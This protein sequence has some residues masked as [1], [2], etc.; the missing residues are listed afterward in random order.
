MTLSK[1]LI[2]LLT[3]LLLVVFIGT[4]FISVKNSRSYIEVQLAS[5]A[6]DAATSLG[7]AVTHH[8]KEGDQAMVTSMTN[9][10]FDRGFYRLIRVESADG[11]VLVERQNQVDFEGIPEWF[12]RMI[13]LQVP[14]GSS[15]LMSGWKQMGHV[16]VTSNPGYAY[17]QLWDNV[18]DTLIWFVLSALIVGGIGISLLRLIVSPLRAMEIQAIAISNQEF[19]AIDTL[20]RTR[21][22][23]GI[24]KAMN[25]MSHKVA[26]VFGELHEL[27]NS[28]CKSSLLDPITELANRTY[29]INTLTERVHSSEEF[30]NGVL[31]LVQVNNLRE[32][33]ELAGREFGDRLLKKVADTLREFEVRYPESIA[34]HISGADFALLVGDISVDDA[35][36]LAAELS[37]KL[38]LIYGD[39]VLNTPDFCHIGMA[40]Y[41]GSQSWSELM[42]AA[43]MALRMAIGS[44]ANGYHL[45]TSSDVDLSG[46][47]TATE[48]RQRIQRAIHNGSVVLQY[49]PVVTSRK[50]TLLHREV[51]VRIREVS[52]TG[53]ETLLSAGAFM[54]QAEG[55]GFTEEI[56]REVIRQILAKVT[57]SVDDEGRYAINLSPHTLSASGF[58]E[59]LG[60]QL[61]RHPDAAGRLLF[62]MPEYAV[63][64]MT[65]KVQILIKLLRRFGSQF[66]IDHFGKSFN[67][68]IYLKLL[69]IDYLKIDGSYFR[70]LDTNH[71]HQFF[72]QT[73]TQ[74]ANSLDIDVIAQSIETSSVM[75]LLPALKI[76]GAQ[77]YM[78]GKPEF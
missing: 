4:F 65:E 24:V 73:L 38:M 42:S 37:N 69:K 19:I 29:F 55:L 67:S 66:G 5:H 77:G 18:I 7:L 17:V 49:Q 57:A 12:I 31:T 25:K 48:W 3:G 1:Q 46:I 20:P 61:E 70:N 54:P 30:H 71:D 52:D 8:L 43:D 22:L 51:L 63:I 60:E 40:Y 26:G 2:A 23:R 58:I 74:M 21:D 47:L 39:G 15:E 35:R 33:N 41:D 11:M 45:L 56:D 10:M 72:V 13:P 27:A 14:E 50:Q 64:A 75:E 34:A 78:V 53:E 76:A 32:F 68:F 59:W 9:A 36:G 16:I 62:E 28:L 6:Q 44:E